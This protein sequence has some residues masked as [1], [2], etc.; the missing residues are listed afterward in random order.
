MTYSR[1][2]SLFQASDLITTCSSNFRQMILFDFIFLILFRTHSQNCPKSTLLHGS[3]SSRIS[4]QVEKV[5]MI[6]ASMERN[7]LPDC[8]HSFLWISH[9]AIFFQWEIQIKTSTENSF[10]DAIKKLTRL[11]IPAYQKSPDRAS[12]HQSSCME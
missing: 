1:S 7:I 6:L 5:F 12:I 8:L 4:D 2:S 9:R 11:S 10:G 3:I